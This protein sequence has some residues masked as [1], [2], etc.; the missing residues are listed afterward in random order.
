[1]VKYSGLPFKSYARMGGWYCLGLFYFLAFPGPIVGVYQF[2][3]EFFYWNYMKS[4]IKFSR[5]YIVSHVL[6]VV[7]NVTRNC[8]CG[9]AL[10]SSRVP[11]RQREVEAVM[12]SWRVDLCLW[13][14]LC[15]E[16]RDLHCMCSE[17]VRWKLRCLQHTPGRRVPVKVI[18][19]YL[20]NCVP[21]VIC[22]QCWFCPSFGKGPDKAYIK[23]VCY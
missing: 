17:G 2:S 22:G 6:F 5:L 18:H 21:K 19:R 12:L 7:S 9:T 13:R 14:W 10:P 8:V 20:W 4:A 3:I 15:K 23:P 11:K 16:H 1:M